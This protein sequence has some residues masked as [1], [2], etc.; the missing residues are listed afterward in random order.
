MGKYPTTQN[1]FLPYRSPL[2]LMLAG[3]ALRSKLDQKYIKKGMRNKTGD[4]RFVKGLNIHRLY[5]TPGAQENFES[6]F[7]NAHTY[8]WEEF[9]ERFEKRKTG[10]GWPFTPADLLPAAQCAYYQEVE[11]SR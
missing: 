10:D 8:N 11:K 1:P 4:K 3:W 2:P 7:D 5:T 9:K 6:Y